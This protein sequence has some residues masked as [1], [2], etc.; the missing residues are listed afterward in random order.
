MDRIES[1]LQ[2]KS[3]ATAYLE[4]LFEKVEESRYPSKDLLNRI[5]R[6]SS[7]VD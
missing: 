7:A 2:T 3:Q 5:A 1:T 4:V 6:V